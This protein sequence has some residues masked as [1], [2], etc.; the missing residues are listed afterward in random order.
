MGTHNLDTMRTFS[1]LVALSVAALALGMPSADEFVPET[2]LFVAEGTSASFEE[3]QQT[4]TSM[5]QAGKTDKDCRKLATESKKEIEKTVKQ[6]QKILNA[7]STGAECTKAHDSTVGKAQTLKDQAD[8]KAADA[9]KAVDKSCDVKVD[10]GKFH[11]SSLKPGKCD[12]FYSKSAYSSAAKKCADAKK[13]KENADGAKGEAAKSL[14][15]TKDAAAK[16]KN[17]CLCKVQKDH[18]S[19]WAEATKSADSNQKA[20]AKAHHIECVLDATPASKC[21]VPTCP[22]VKKPTIV[23]AAKNAVCSFKGVAMIVNGASNTLHYGSAY[24]TNSATG[25]LGGGNSKTD[26]FFEKAKKATFTFRT[27][28]QTRSISVDMGGKS[29]QQ[30]FKAGAS[31][32]GLSLGTWRGLGGSKKFAYQNNCNRQGFDVTA[33]HG[34]KLRFGIIFNEQNNCNSPD[35]MIGVGMQSAAKMSAGGYCGCCQQGGKCQKTSS[36]VTITVEGEK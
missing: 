29:L 11:L 9:K 24:W 14:K 32:T 10:F 23:S 4:V 3:A 31:Y 6:A 7:L 15:K 1:L 25:D 34:Y 35:T 28:S 20:W 2:E 30:K 8:Q 26:L 12:Q 13:A 33:A 21:T 17:K 5:T 19:A 22:A 27:G 36:K 16:D 18:K